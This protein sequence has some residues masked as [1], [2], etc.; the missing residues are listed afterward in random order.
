MN[1]AELCQ[2]SGEALRFRFDDREREIQMKQNGKHIT[3]LLAALLSAAIL[4]VRWYSGTQSHCETVETENSFRLEFSS[5]SGTEEHLLLLEA[6]EELTVEWLLQA[7]SMDIQIA[8]PG[9]KAVYTADG[10]RASDNP[11]AEFS[12]TIPQAGGY[13]I[14][15]SGRKAGGKFRLKRGNC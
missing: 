7:G 6:G 1:N 3:I 9:E 13:R 10:V 4:T 8:I 2:S 12:V 5:W 11:S 14:T 15:V